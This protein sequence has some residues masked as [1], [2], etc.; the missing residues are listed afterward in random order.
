M[1]ALL[2]VS[3]RLIYAGINPGKCG[4]GTPVRKAC[5][6]ADLSHQLRSKGWAYSFHCHDNRVFGKPGS[7][8]V[9]HGPKLFDGL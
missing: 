6:I 8:F 2:V 3:A 9:H 7:G 5:H 4:N 1:D